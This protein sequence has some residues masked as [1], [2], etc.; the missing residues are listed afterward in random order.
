M[1][2]SRREFLAL[3]SLALLTG[4][5]PPGVSA[6][7]VGS[8]RE[9]RLDRFTPLRR[10]VGIYENRGGVMGWLI[11]AAGVVVV[12]SQFADTAGTFAEG[13]RGRTTR[14]IDVLLNTHH[15][16]D[17][18]GGNAVLRP[19]AGRIV[20][21]ARA[22]ELLRGN[23]NFPV[24]GRPDTPFDTEWSVTLG[25]ETI[26][27][28]HYGRGA[29]TGGDATVFFREANIVHM[30][31]LMFNRAFPFIDGP[32]G[33]SVRGWVEVL[34]AVVADHDGDTL[35]IF[36][37][38][39]EGAPFTGAAADLLVQRDFLAA[40]LEKAQR[41]RREG[42]SVEQLVA[43]GPP[44]GFPGHSG[45]ENRLTALYTVAYAELER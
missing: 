45:P 7:P 30:G 41:G 34:E 31:D 5:L 40:A 43:S 32:S 1:S 29:H 22:A 4:A 44:D 25:D 21:H 38:A 18:V 17:H 26:R 2:W 9:G 27:A 37:H 8:A 39:G 15:H 24:D 28:R 13:L 35:Y 14:T 36:G 16:G 6:G 42:L 10:N 19:M 33:A 11:S 20:A 12:D 3:S 23:E